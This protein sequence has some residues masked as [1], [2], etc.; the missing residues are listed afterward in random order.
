MSTDVGGI[1][2]GSN[3]IKYNSGNPLPLF[4]I[5]ALV[6]ILLCRL[7]QYP[8]SY[9]RQPRVIAEVIGGILLGPTAFGRIDGFTATLFPAPSLPLINLISNFGW[10]SSCSWWSARRTIGISLAGMA[11]PFGVGVAVSYALYQQLDEQYKKSGFGG[12]LLFCGIAM[13][14]TAFP[15]LARILTE[16]NLLKTHVGSITISAA[17]V[18]DAVS[19]CLLAL[20]IAIVNAGSGIHALY[21]FLVAIG[22]VLFLILAVR[23]AFIRY[24]IPRFYN[25]E[26]GPSQFIVTIVVVMVFI[27]AFFTDALGIH[28]IFGG[29][30]IGVIMPHEGG[31]AVKLTEKIEDLVT[32]VFLPLYF[33]LS[34][35]KTEIGLLN[36]GKSWGMVILVIVVAVGGK[37]VGCSSVAKLSG[38]TWREALSVGFL[39]NCK[40]LVE[41]IVL[42]LGLDAGVID[43]KVFAILVLMALVTTFITTPMVMWLYPPRYWR[44]VKGMTRA[45]SRM[46]SPIATMSGAVTPSELL[47]C[48][49]RMRQVPAIMQLIRVLAPRRRKTN[50]RRVVH[51]L[52]L[53]ELGQRESAVM[54]GQEIHEITRHDPVSNVLRAFGQLS[55]VTVDAAMTVAEMT[56]YPTAVADHSMD[57][58]AGLVV[59]PWTITTQE[60]SSGGI[61]DDE[62]VPTFDANSTI[63]YLSQDPRHASFVEGLF[64]TVACSCAV[65]IDRGLGNGEVTVRFE[66]SNK[67]TAQP[68]PTRPVTMTSVAVA[69]NDNTSTLNRH[70]SQGTIA[71]TPAEMSEAQTASDALAHRDTP[72]YRNNNNNNNDVDDEFASFDK[73]GEAIALFFG[74]ADDRR[75]VETAQT[76]M[77]NGV[78]VTVIRYRSPGEIIPESID[79]TLFAELSNRITVIDVTMSVADARTD[80]VNRVKELSHRDVVILGRNEKNTS[81]PVVGVLGTTAVQL[82]KAVVVLV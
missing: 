27:S 2:A 69:P 23:P 38:M 75:A 19:W 80:A 30:V 82:L 53:V 61:D 39:M 4:L 58:D 9:L 26:V 44:N 68:A 66:Q 72:G 25:P 45:N 22:Y 76:M 57:I 71:S 20:V 60:N 48:L 47:V 31:F 79:Q 56:S 78:R 50:N 67:N 81:E 46:A 3:P 21:I 42:N 10:S 24:V 43:K 74:G 63:S 28:A 41:L 64:D 65:L 14:I 18:D 62:I 5:Q 13:A 54:R 55:G 15:V 8:L 29:F 12:F 33:A 11:L 77:R 73:T 37:V 1:L 51:A 40:G 34:G 17:A 32:V 59:V 7:L 49:S 52:R 36:D 16:L 35:L 70:D 6:I